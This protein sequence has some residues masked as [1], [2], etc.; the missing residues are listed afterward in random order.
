MHSPELLLWILYEGRGV[1]E[2]TELPRVHLEGDLLSVEPGASEEE[3]RS[4]E[5]LYTVHRWP[6]LALFFGG[7]NSVTPEEGAGDSR[8]GGCSLE[9]S[10]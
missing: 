5:N 7:A 10:A 9:F 4:L 8:R 6:N 2:S 3:L 1:K